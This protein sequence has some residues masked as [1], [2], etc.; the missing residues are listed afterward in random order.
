MRN[1]T[2][3]YFILWIVFIILAIV[4]GGIGIYIGIRK[5]PSS[6]YPLFT[7]S[8]ETSGTYTIIDKEKGII[9]TSSG[10]T[11]Q[12]DPFVINIPLTAGPKINKIINEYK[13]NTQ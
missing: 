1:R 8:G 6:V 5:Q 10:Y 11:L 13:I 3:I 4:F 7:K 12:I 9:E 2:N